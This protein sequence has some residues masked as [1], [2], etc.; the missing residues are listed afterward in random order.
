MVERSEFNRV[1]ELPPKV[2]DFW[3]Y[4]YLWFYKFQPLVSNE[5]YGKVFTRA[6]LFSFFLFSVFVFI[7]EYYS[8]GSLFL[9]TKNSWPIYIGL[10][11]VSAFI[12]LIG[13]LAPLCFSTLTSLQPLFD[14]SS[15]A[16][17]KRLDEFVRRVLYGPRNLLFSIIVTIPAAIVGNS[18]IVSRDDNAYQQ[19]RDLVDLLRIMP[20]SLWYHNT[21]FNKLIIPAIVW[22]IAIFFI[23][24]TIRGFVAYIQLMK[25]IGDLNF[26][27]LYVVPIAALR[28]R[29]LTNFNFTVSICYSVGVLL[30]LSAFNLK[31]RYAVAIIAA[32][33]SISFLIVS[34]PYLYFSRRLR[35]EVDKLIDHVLG[36]NLFSKSDFGA[37]DRDIRAMLEVV[38]LIKDLPSGIYELRLGA[39]NAVITTLLALAVGYLKLQ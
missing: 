21:S 14:I 7:S 36:A 15:E 8:F 2:Y 28:F 17:N 38:N 37:Q 16:Y 9:S 4:R 39:G 19:D 1:S 30:V 23:I 34:L 29:K 22:T 10:V 6:I 3:P 33:V 27:S 32:L 26:R 5:Y 31:S 25:F 13:V 11:G 18:G 35:A 20:S 12:F 24:L